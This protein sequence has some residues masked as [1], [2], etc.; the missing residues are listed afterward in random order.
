MIWVVL[1]ATLAFAAII[2][3]W[4]FLWKS[5]RTAEDQ[6]QGLDVYKYQLKEL[7]EDVER[8][9]VSEADAEP[10][11]LEIKRRILR[12][13]EEQQIKQKA[14]T[15]LAVK[16]VLIVLV[17]SLG[18]LR[19]Y[20]Y[21]GSPDLPS[22]PLASRDIQAEKRQFATQDLGSLVKRLAEK[23]QE[24]PDNLDG[25]VLLARTLNR[26]SRYEDAANTYLQATRLA[27]EDADLYV[28]AAENFFFLADGTV[29]DAALQN[30]KK[31]YSLDPLHPGA[32]FYLALYDAQNGEL[33]VALTKWSNLYKDSEP[34]APYMPIL[35]KRIEAVAS[36]L[37]KDV[38]ELLA[39]K[40][41]PTGDKG[42]SREDMEA[43]AELSAADRQ[44]MINSMVAGL[45][46]RMA[47]NPDFPGLMKLGRAYSTL[48]QFE[49]SADA[50]SRAA[51]LQPKNP[52][53]LVFQAL[54]LVLGSEGREPPE[55]ALQVYRKILDLD[56]T[57]PEA[58]WYLGVAAALK[59]DTQE[60]RTHWEQMLKL[61][62]EGSKIYANV[63]Q[64]INS[65]S[66]QSEN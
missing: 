64:A 58:H 11:R 60:A 34:E 39:S 59:G 15:H 63:Q 38:S 45:A 65:L 17:L 22:K 31:A 24:Q 20:S 6:L 40:E 37:G 30:F 49:K 1:C 21:L 62:P 51:V 54:A 57:I 29:S 46:D 42:P 43:A 28:G 26:M 47:E 7:E 55:T 12:A 9:V 61:V 19:L 4:P 13:G 8:G 2:L 32:R 41:L 23:L 48:K 16:A 44:D 35:A 25:W 56:E 66:Q 33:A 14:E 3:I 53:P 18:S 5:S 27:P 50:Y 36:E 10:V 52:E